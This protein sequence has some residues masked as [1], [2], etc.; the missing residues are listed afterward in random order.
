MFYFFWAGSIRNNKDCPNN[1]DH[2]TTSG[3]WL[4]FQIECA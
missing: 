3:T 1:R 4:A 2:L